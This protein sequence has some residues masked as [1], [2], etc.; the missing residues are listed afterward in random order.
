MCLSDF[1]FTKI[2]FVAIVF[3]KISSGT[4]VCHN[5]AGNILLAT[6]LFA[7]SCLTKVCVTESRL[8][9]Y[10]LTESTL[11]KY[12]LKQQCLTKCCHTQISFRFFNVSVSTRQSPLFSCSSLQ[13]TTVTAS[14]WYQSRAF[15]WLT[16]HSLTKS[17]ETIIGQEIYSRLMFSVIFL[18]G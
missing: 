7:Y 4:S 10:G 5:V 18:C 12:C 6:I 3:G 17:Y 15:L 16:T 13:S 14:M 8:A 2:V 11:T 1:W 9:K